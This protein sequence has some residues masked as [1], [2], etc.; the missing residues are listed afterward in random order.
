L[1]KRYFAEQAGAGYEAE[2]QLLS[3]K[4]ILGS[5]EKVHHPRSRSAKLRG[6]V[7]IKNER[8]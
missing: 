4:P 2:L 5:N 6:A 1:V 7:K 8:T 3:K